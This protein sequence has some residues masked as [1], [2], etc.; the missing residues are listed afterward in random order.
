MMK[1]SPI[2]EKYL[3]DERDKRDEEK[4]HKKEYFYASD[5]LVDN[6][7]EGKCI[8]RLC[9]EFSDINPEPLNN[10]TLRIFAI[11]EVLHEWIQDILIKTKK[12]KIIEEFTIVYKQDGDVFK[13]TDEKNKIIIK[14]PVEIHGRMDVMLIDNTIVEIKTVSKGAFFYLGNAPKQGHSLQLQLY[15]FSKNVKEGSI[16]YINKD[17]GEF[18]E[19]EVKYDANFVMESLERFTKAKE[20]IDRYLKTGELPKHPFIK[21]Y[22]LCKFCSYTKECWRETK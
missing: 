15:M 5:S 4:G 7:E 16:F 8:R 12:A 14:D 2:I 1:I 11:G 13:N 20:V 10:K 21:S 3:K 22:W 17:T 19:F 6:I 9:Y 18:K